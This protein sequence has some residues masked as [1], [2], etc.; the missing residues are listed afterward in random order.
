M[1]VVSA[2]WRAA[3]SEPTTWKMSPACG[4][5]LM[6]DTT[7]GVAGGASLTLRPRSSDRARTRP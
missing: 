3:F 5:S 6:P 1:S 4:T 2:I 7:T